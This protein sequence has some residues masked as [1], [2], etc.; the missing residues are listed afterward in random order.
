VRQVL[1]WDSEF[2]GHRIAR[3]EVDAVSAAHRDE[4]EA[5]CRDQRV[6]CA[7]L[8]VAAG[9][10]ATSDTAI[11]S[12]FRLVDVRVK[13]EA[14]VGAEPDTAPVAGVRLVVPADLEHLRAIARGSHA[15]SRFYADGHFDRQRC[16]DLFVH[17]VDRSCQGWADRVFVAESDGAA[18]GYV[19]VHRR[20]DAAEIGLVGVSA[21]A[22]GRGWATRMLVSARRW[23]AEEGLSRVTVVTQGR[24]RSAMGLYQAAGYTVSDIHLWYHRWFQLP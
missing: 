16:D 14:L 21:T 5:W 4:T 13:L 7:Y 23:C 2:F 22:R 12:G 11:S 3:L 17:W 6:A 8:L 15:D 9:D 19:T 24:N 1:D 20:T 18:V 10:Q